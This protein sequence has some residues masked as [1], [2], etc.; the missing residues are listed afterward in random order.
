[1]KQ[2]FLS[3]LTLIF[4]NNLLAQGNR[5]ITKQD[6]IR[7]SYD[8]EYVGTADGACSK[9]LKLV[10]G[11]KYKITVYLSNESG[12]KLTYTGGYI[13]IVSFVAPETGCQ[14]LRQDINVNI[15][16]NPGDIKQAS[17]YFTIQQ[18]SPSGT[19]KVFEYILRGYKF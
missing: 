5:L 10:P 13:P 16:L 6:G 14:P 2:L 8:L 4:I 7:L 12:K 11:D 1:M 15:P 9:D 3:V 17:G 18:G 19:I